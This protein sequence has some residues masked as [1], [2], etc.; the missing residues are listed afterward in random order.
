MHFYCLKY[1]EKLF[2][3]VD[4]FNGITRVTLVIRLEFSLAGRITMNSFN[5]R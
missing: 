2:M 5:M 3:T 4:L 1:A